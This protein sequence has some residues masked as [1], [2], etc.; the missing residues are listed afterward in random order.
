ML[1]SY[2]T[3]K[4]ETLCSNV[5]S[6]KRLFPD[7]ATVNRFYQR[8]DQLAAFDSLAD[9]PEDR[10]WHL[11]L[12]SGDKKGWWSVKI[13]GAYRICFVPEGDFETTPDGGIDRSTVGEIKITFIGDY[14]E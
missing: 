1:I 2:K 9:V 8:L 3:Q 4:H 13:R 12:L 14:H 5:K 6:A 11:H 10:L 7:M